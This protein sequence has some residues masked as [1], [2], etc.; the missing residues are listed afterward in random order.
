M[1]IQISTRSRMNSQIR[2]IS[3]SSMGFA[4]YWGVLVRGV[5]WL[6]LGCYALV[7]FV[8]WLRVC[9]RALRG[10]CGVCYVVLV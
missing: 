5:L 8:C 10:V 2:Q 7:V 6:C 4:S 1:T 3:R 9:V